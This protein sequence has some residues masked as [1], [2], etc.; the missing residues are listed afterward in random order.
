MEWSAVAP[1]GSTLVFFESLLHSGGICRSRKE[2]LLI[3]GGYAPDFFQPWFHYEPDPDF[4]ATL[5]EDEQPFY[6][7]SRKYHWT[8]M[9]R[10]LRDEV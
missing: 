9:P 4:V 10:D 6:T 7:G 2:R 5:P 1:A 3:I 8:K